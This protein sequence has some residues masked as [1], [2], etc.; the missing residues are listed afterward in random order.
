MEVG[1]S[2]VQPYIQYYPSH[3]RLFPYAKFPTSPTTLGNITM[4]MCKYGRQHQPG[5]SH[6]M[7]GQDCGKWDKQNGALDDTLIV[8]V[9]N[10][11]LFYHCLPSL[12]SSLY[13][14]ALKSLIC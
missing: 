8:V 7:A 9:S 6:R 3:P 2:W 10:M 5:G 4:A 13:D 1:D 12:S 11:F 14:D